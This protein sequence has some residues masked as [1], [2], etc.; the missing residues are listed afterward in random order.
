MT[1]SRE[2]AKRKKSTQPLHHLPST[3]E[4]R[5][6]FK[7]PP[8]RQNSVAEARKLGSSGVN[9]PRVFKEIMS[10]NNESFVF[11]FGL[12][13]VKFGTPRD[14]GRDV[15]SFRGAASPNVFRP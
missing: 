3:F 8:F 9:L 14:Y 5:V 13:R 1:R 12:A 2:L 7:S 15:R 6:L 10:N 4:T 11:E